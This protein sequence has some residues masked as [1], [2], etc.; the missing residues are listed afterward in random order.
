M[1][2]VE[3]NAEVLTTTTTTFAQPQ[4]IQQEQATTS[5]Y[6]RI[7]TGL[8]NNAQHDSLKKSPF[9]IY[10]KVGQVCLANISKHCPKHTISGTHIRALYMFLGLQ[11]AFAF[12]VNVSKNSSQGN[13]IET[14]HGA[15]GNITIVAKA[16]WGP[17]RFREVAMARLFLVQKS[18]AN[19]CK[20]MQT[21]N[22]VYLPSRILKMMLLCVLV[23]PFNTRWI[24]L[25]AIAKKDKNKKNV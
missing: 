3:E 24:H 21:P 16:T 14:R 7:S 22:L 15:V 17:T 1:G 4:Q 11:R 6:H 20:S 13:Q 19:L 12:F 9:W 5:I 8:Y 2:I 10:I 23:F 25:I 18:K